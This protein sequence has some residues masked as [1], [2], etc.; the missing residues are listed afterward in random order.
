MSKTIMALAAVLLAGGIGAPA[1]QGQIQG[2][3]QGQGSGQAQTAT[4]PYRQQVPDTVPLGPH[5][6]KPRANP[7]AAGEVT[8]WKD[9]GSQPAPRDNANGGTREHSGSVG[10]NANTNPLKALEARGQPRQEGMTE[11]AAPAPT[12]RSTMNRGAGQ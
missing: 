3:M 6:D 9:L 11:P 2:Q 7:S 12:P 10:V 4:P 5:I 1:A 8:G